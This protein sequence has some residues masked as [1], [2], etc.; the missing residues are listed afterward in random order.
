LCKGC[1]EVADLVS[2]NYPTAKWF[3]LQTGWRIDDERKRYVAREA[4]KLLRL[5]GLG[6]EFTK[7]F[8]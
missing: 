1:W 8:E 7:T 4:Y 2:P 3:Y 6:E 5:H